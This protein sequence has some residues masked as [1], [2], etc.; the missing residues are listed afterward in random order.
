MTKCRNPCLAL[1][2]RYSEI[3][4]ENLRFQPTPPSFGTLVG[5]DPEFCGDF[6]HQ[7]TRVPGLSYGIVFVMLSLAI[8]VQCRRV[9]WVKMVL[10]LLIFSLI[11]LLFL[12]LQVYIFVMKHTSFHVYNL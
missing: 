1:F 12:I 9:T 8:W 10:I 3:L 11:Y 2:L 5:G 6:W 7:K 4:V